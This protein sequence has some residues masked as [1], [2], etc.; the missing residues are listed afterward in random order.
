MRLQDQVAVVTGGS[1]GIGKAICQAFAAEGAKVAIVYRGSQE[2]AAQLAQELQSMGREA[3]AWQVDVAD[4]AAVMKCAEEIHQKWGRVDILVNNAGIIKDGLFMQMDPANWK[5]VIN[6][7]LGG[8]FNFSRAVVE[9]MFRQRKGR[10]INISSVAADRVNRG[11][12]NYVASKGAINAFTKALAIE[13]ASRG[14]TVNAIAPGFIE[15]DM[16]ETVRNMAGDAIKKMIP[17]RRYGKPEDIAKVA[18]F[19]ASDDSAYITGQVVTVDGGL[20]LGVMA[21]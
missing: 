13:L 21:G 10:V 7:N 18:V 8:T 3:Q 20:G 4:T 9:W 12:A 19:L 11:Q 16:S 6:T 17:M 14:V 2:A 1:R 5:D 15:T